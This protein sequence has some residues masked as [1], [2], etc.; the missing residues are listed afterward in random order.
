M[1]NVKKFL[2]YFTTSFKE[3][4]KEKKQI[5]LKEKLSFAKHPK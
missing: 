1:P 2:F 5:F 3:K 4:V